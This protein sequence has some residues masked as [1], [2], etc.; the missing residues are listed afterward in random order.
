MNPAATDQSLSSPENPGPGRPVR[1]SSAASAE[2]DTLERVLLATIEEQRRSRRWKIFFRFAW[3]ALV[4]VA[5]LAWFRGAAG[6]AMGGPGRHTALIDIRGVIDSEGDASAE[7]IV[8]SLGAAFQDPRTAGVIIRI[9]SPGGSPVQSGIIYQEIRRLRAKYP[10]T[11]VHAVVEEVC[12]SGGY[13]IAAA[14][15]KIF[16]DQASL[17]GSIG[18]LM[19]GFGFSDALKKLGVERRLL[20]AGDN[21]AFLDS[22]SP[23]S[24]RQKTHAQRMLNEIHQQFIDAVKAGRG[25]RLKDDPDIFSG[26]VWTGA[27]SIELGLADALGSLTQVARD[28]VQAEDIVDF[29]RHESLAD[30][31]VRRLGA[32]T[33]QAILGQL[34]S[35]GEGWTLR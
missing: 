3:M 15:D 25:D 32:Q 26:L 21:K 2:R 23:M 8:E 35:L 29:S 7:N 16:V 9:S 20:T 18:V 31:V 27:R 34:R 4:A 28:V 13:Y 19:D 10:D 24:E 5:L 1:P 33:T 17:I 6:P 14:A 12:A 11:P 30:R 22:F